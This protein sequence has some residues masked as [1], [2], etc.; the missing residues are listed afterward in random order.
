MTEG[1]RREIL[2]PA[3]ARP[4]GQHGVRGG[5]RRGRLQGCLDCVDGGTVVHES[6][7]PGRQTF[8][9][10]ATFVGPTFRVGR[11]FRPPQDYPRLLWILLPGGSVGSGV[12]RDQPVYRTRELKWAAISAIPKLIRNFGAIPGSSEKV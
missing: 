8:R 12:P 1:G 11:H 9:S 10:G 7:H 6:E 2:R 4:R 5:A 3:A